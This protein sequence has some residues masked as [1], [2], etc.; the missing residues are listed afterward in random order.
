MFDIDA[1]AR[2]VSVA[3]AAGFVLV[4][5]DDSPLPVGQIPVGRIEAGARAAYLSQRTTRIG[6]VPTLQVAVTEPLHLATQLAALDH[7][8]LGRGGWVVGAENSAAAHATIGSRPLSE[9]DD[10]RN[11]VRDVIEVARQLWD[12]WEDDANIRA[13][14][15]GRCAPGA[16]RSWGRYVR[17]RAVDGFNLLPQL[18]PGTIE[19]VV[20]RLVPELQERG[21][22]RTEYE[23]STLREHLDLA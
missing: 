6:L 2:H 12:S 21:I 5:I 22:Y 1:L 13:V 3:E 10:L 16:C 20:D 14:A 8:S 4:T 9:P 19:D 7:A 15:T 23:G 18:L 11:E 17:T